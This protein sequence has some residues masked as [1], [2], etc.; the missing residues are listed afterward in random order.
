MNRLFRIALLALTLT[1]CGACEDKN[2]EQP[3][4]KPNAN[5]IAGTWQ[6][7][8]FGGETLAEGTYVYIEFIRK[9]ALFEMYQ[10]V[11][12]FPLR[13]LTGRFGITEEETGEYMIRGM[14][15]HSVGD[16]KHVYRITE[17][18]A[19]RMVWTAQDDEEDVSVYVHCDGIPEEIR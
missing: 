14:Y 3:W 8:E 17:F 15:D 5:N 4:L 6:L 18:T 12:S 7:A 9:D 2:E 1:L 16:W 19:G 10:N 11:D 13:K